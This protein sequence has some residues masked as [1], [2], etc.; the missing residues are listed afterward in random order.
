[1]CYFFSAYVALSVVLSLQWGSGL[2]SD[3]QTKQLIVMRPL[4]PYRAKKTLHTG[5]RT[6]LN[7]LFRLP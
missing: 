1:M 2:A 5:V 4:F 6:G 7:Y 3:F